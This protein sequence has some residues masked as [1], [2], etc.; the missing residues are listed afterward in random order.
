MADNALAFLDSEHEIYT[1]HKES[2]KREE[3][4]LFG[5]DLAIAELTKWKQEEA[6][7]YDSRLK[8]ASYLNFPK[9]HA[10]LLAG[11]LGKVAPMPNFGTL[12]E[13]IRSREDARGAPTLAELIFYN[14]DGVGSDGSQW[15]QWMRGV[16]ERAIATG[17]RWAL[18]DMPARIQTD[19]PLT[20]E[21][22]LNGHRPYLRELSP[23]QVR[24]WEIT[25]GRL[26]W[27]VIR[28][29]VRPK[30]STGWEPLPK[31][32]GYYL[33]VRQGY[34]GLGADYAGGGWWIFDHQKGIVNFGDWSKT[35]GQIPLV[36]LIAESSQGTEDRPAI[37]RSL[38]MELGQIAVSLMNRISERNYDASDA[39]KSIK[40]VMG[41]GKESFN[42]TLDKLEE[43]SVVV[44]VVG[45]MTPDGKYTVPQIYDSSAGAV[46]AEVF[47]TI[48]KSTIEEAHEIMVRQLTSADDASGVSRDKGFSEGTSPLLAGLAMGRESFENA[49]IYFLE[50]RGGAEQPRGFV[51]WPAEFEIAPVLSKID[52]TIERMQK[53]GARSPTLE[54]ELVKR[55]AVEDGLWPTNEED[56]DAAEAELIA[57]T[58]AVTAKVKGDAMQA[59]VGAQVDFETAAG[60][61]GFDEDEVTLIAAGG[62]NNQNDDDEDRRT[63]PNQPPA[64]EPSAVE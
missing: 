57:S 21:D 22:E 13:E 62:S 1:S 46:S 4:R 25:D 47:T 34:D 29:R 30:D 54:A 9:L 27:A 63:D 3:Q 8:E 35:K 7:H 39:A 51:T 55:A 61:A 52:R 38:T 41:V 26:D 12:G 48:I 58:K 32:P 36:A 44:P 17:H 59:L 37:S 28:V 11:H 40:F 24:N 10:S 42:L 33:L 15:H 43:G 56:G 23:L 53:I 31:T 18:I 64:P 16:Q 50:L 19:S 49:V 5:G 14:V 20:R 45:E 2:W 60:L 6:D